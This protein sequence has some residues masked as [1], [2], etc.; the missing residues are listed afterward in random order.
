M[1][2][3]TTREKAVL[4]NALDG[5]ATDIELLTLGSVAENCQIAECTYPDLLGTFH[6]NAAVVLDIANRLRTETE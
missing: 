5:L 3:P 4:T 6:T 2:E 1:R